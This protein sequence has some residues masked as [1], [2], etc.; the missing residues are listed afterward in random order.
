M[1]DCIAFNQKDGKFT[2]EFENGVI[3]RGS[4]EQSYAL[5]NLLC[6]SRQD[7]NIGANRVNK[8]G[9]AGSTA[10]TREFFS[11]GWTYYIEK[12]TATQNL[13]LLINEFNRAC[14]RD[15]RDGY[16]DRKISIISINRL[17]KTELKI[18]L[19]ID[20]LQTEINIKV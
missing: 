12:N 13:G 11:R 15:L 2:I 1:T 14:L 4:K 10:Y 3:K 6:F 5:H 9:W 18:R 19:G 16:I 8:L 7:P 20:Q 17:S